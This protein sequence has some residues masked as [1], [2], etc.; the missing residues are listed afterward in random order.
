MPINN[1]LQNTFLNKKV[2]ITGHT[3]FKGTWLTTWLKMLGANITGIS[4]DI[5]T[6]PSHFKKTP[7]SNE[8]NDLRLDIRSKDLNKHI[9][10]IKPDFIFHL[11]AQSLVT[12]SH[13]DP[14]DT[15][16]TNV[17]GTANLLNSL[18]SYKRKCI[19]IFITSD[20]CYDNKEW[21]WGYRETDVLGGSDPYSGSKASSEILI[22]SF[23]K[24]FF[25]KSHPVKVASV[26]AGNVIGGG[27]WS[28]DRIIPDVIRAWSSNKAVK[29]RNPNAT[30]PWQHVLEPLSG[31]LTLASAMSKNYNLQGETFNFGPN[32]NQIKTVRNVVRSIHKYLPKKSLVIKKGSNKNNEHHFLKL[33]CDKALNTLNWTST[34]NFDETIKM[35]MEWY[36]SYYKNPKNIYQTTK[37]QIK[38]YEDL[39]KKRSISW[40]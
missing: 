37:L 13:E 32:D 9:N 10:K 22:N 38:K 39:A 27:D 25:T 6:Y 30:R 15:W 24:S 26:R 8:I 34:L 5:P 4:L 29:V 36:L 14:L 7:L 23:A 2:L 33:N 17:I 11:A 12:K 18:I 1:K 16:S 28:S 20:K 31:Y 21:E 19:A 35:T 3:G 40:S